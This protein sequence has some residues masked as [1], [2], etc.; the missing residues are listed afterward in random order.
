MIYKKL[1]TTTNN[2]HIVDYLQVHVVQS[3][4]NIFADSW[5]MV[6]HPIRN[7]VIMNI[8]RDKLFVGI[9]W[10]NSPVVFGDFK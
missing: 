9:V 4:L 10:T 1:S 3:I 5:C 7:T 8:I 6:S 2:L